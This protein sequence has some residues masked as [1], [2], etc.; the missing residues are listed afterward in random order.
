[1]E[2]AEPNHCAR[3]NVNFA[4]TSSAYLILMIYVGMYAYIRV[5]SAGVDNIMA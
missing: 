2:A 1:M 5:Y 4:I 3:D